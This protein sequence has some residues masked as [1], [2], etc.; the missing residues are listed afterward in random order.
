M[1][2]KILLVDNDKDLRDSVHEILKSGG[3]P[4]VETAD[5]QGALSLLTREEF[6]LML[7]GITL[8]DRSGFRVLEFCNEKHLTGK[9][10][11]ITGTAKLG[12]EIRSTIRGAVNCITEPYDPDY[13]LKSIKLILSGESQTNLQIIRAGDFIKSTPTGALDMKASKLGL[14]QIAATGVDLLDFTVLIDLRDVMSRLSTNDIFELASGLIEYGKTF[15]R[16]TAVLTRADE[17]NDQATFF[18]TVAQNRGFRVKTFTVFEDAIVWL[19]GI[20]QL[21][22]DSRT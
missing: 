7:L 9:V 6:D 5:C 16:R 3:Y 18:E 20:I 4:V 21:I 11:V 10:I 14:A 8:P 12:N 2:A 19:S 15:R 22:A 1:A 17:D 13:L